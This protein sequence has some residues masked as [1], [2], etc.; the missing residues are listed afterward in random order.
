MRRC[1]PSATIGFGQH[2]SLDH[3]GPTWPPQSEVE[4]CTLGGASLKASRADQSCVSVPD[5]R[6]GATET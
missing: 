4:D 2:A 1:K 3:G 6:L 5:G